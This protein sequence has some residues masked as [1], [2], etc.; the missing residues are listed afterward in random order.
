M[1]VAEEGKENPT[2]PSNNTSSSSEQW[3]AP[4]ITCT[5]LRCT[6]LHCTMPYCTVLTLLQRL[7]GQHTAGISAATPVL[8]CSKRLCG[9]P[10]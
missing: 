7:G 8:S 2:W 9:E 1:T 4:Y 5:R 6:V 3:A 10:R